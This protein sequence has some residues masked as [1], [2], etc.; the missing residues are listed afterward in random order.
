MNQQFFIL[1][2]GP[3]TGKTTIINGF[4]ETYARIHQLDLDPDHYNDDVF[5]ILLAANCSYLA[6]P[7]AD[8]IRLSLF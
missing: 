3:G 4:I 5:P 1:T 6:S 2:G 8:I 7:V